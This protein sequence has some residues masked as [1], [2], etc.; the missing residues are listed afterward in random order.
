ML[1]LGHPLSGTARLF[2]SFPQAQRGASGKGAPCHQPACFKSSRRRNSTKF[3]HDSASNHTKPGTMSSSC[4]D[5]EANL[6]IFQ[7]LPSSI[8]SDQ[9]SL[10]DQCF[11][12]GQNFSF[13]HC[14]NN[15]QA[16]RIILLIRQ[17]WPKQLKFSRL[18]LRP[19]FLIMNEFC[20]AVLSLLHSLLHRWAEGQAFRFAAW[21]VVIST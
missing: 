18:R 15:L 1:E 4:P 16:G 3:A 6:C 19:S 2:L 8:V 10:P 21:H 20:Y 13:P 5:L 7:M 12:I 11:R 17:K 14:R 9:P